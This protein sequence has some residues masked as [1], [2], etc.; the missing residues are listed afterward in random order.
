MKCPRCLSTEKVK[1]GFV[2]DRQRYQCKSC[3]YHYSTR[4]K[5]KK[6]SY[7]KRLALFLHLE[8]MGYRPIEDLIDVSNVSIMNWMNKMTTQLKPLKSDRQRVKTINRE[9]VREIINQEKDGKMLLIN[10]KDNKSEIFYI[11]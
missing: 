3:G 2:N 7:L 11:K 1:D 4:Q 5:G 8:G 6:P 9:S 10:L